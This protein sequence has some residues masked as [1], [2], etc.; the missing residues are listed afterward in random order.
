MC[1][2]SSD[3]VN[4]ITFLGVGGDKSPP[5]S[6][7]LHDIN[8][9]NRAALLNIGFQLSRN[10]CDHMVMHDV[11]LL[12]INDHLKYNYHEDGPYHIASPQL[13]PRYHYE[14]FVGGILMLTREQFIKVN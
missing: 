9:F 13:H 12:P 8:R 11:D 10:N 3:L 7:Y 14:K 5:L 2:T 6:Q 1:C 4:S